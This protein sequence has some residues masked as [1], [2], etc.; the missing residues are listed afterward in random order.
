MTENEAIDFLEDEIS[1]LKD[2]RDGASGEI[3]AYVFKEING[4]E[5]IS[6]FR[7]II[8]FVTELKQYR[9]I[10]TVEGVREAVEKT[11]A[12]K[13]KKIGGRH[14]RFS[15]PTCGNIVGWD[16][17]TLNCNRCGQRLEREE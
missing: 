5:R 1:G 9:E 11:K 10:G 16:F 15:C 7:T 17:S 14:K 4:Q 12:K 6:A 2:Q 8:G 3:A 13:A